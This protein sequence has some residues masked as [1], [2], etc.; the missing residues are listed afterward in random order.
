MFYANMNREKVKAQEPQ[1]TFGQLGSKL[2]AL[3]KGLEE[4]DKEVY[5][6]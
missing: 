3:W 2:G 5:C 4:K 6:S 1:I